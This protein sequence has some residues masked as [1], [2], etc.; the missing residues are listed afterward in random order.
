MRSQ[1]EQPM[2]L[3]GTWRTGDV[4]I[5][6]LGVESRLGDLPADVLEGPLLLSINSL[7]HSCTN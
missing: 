6:I 3:L 4:E 1:L 2:G 5:E 7:V